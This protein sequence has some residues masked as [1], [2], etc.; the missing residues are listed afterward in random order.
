MTTRP[1]VNLETTYLGMTLPHPVI[2]SAS[3][4]TGDIDR[5]HELAEA[6]APAV[7]LPSLFEEQIEHDAMAVHH[8]FEFGSG[9]FA[10]AIS[11]YFPEVDDCN[12]GPSAYLA[13]VKAATSELNIPVIASLNG[14][15]PGG[16]TLYAKILEDAGVDALELN[17]YLVGADPLESSNDVENRYLDLISQVRSEVDLPLAVK[18]GPYFSSIGHMARRMSEAGADS[19]V[20]FNRFYQPDIDLNTLAVD[21]S[22]VLSSPTEL[23]LTLR[24]IALLHGRI[25][26][27]LAATTGVHEAAEALKLI[28]AG[29]DV[30]MM[31]SALLRHG[32]SH[33]GQVVAG[34][35]S[36][37]SQHEYS[38]VAQAK[39]SL[40]HSNSPHPEAYERA[41]YMRT[42]VAYSSDWRARNARPG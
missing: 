19:L 29:A 32:A 26:C 15:T 13:L 25:D 33:L 1:P 9:A 14:T 3:P 31:A 41:N 7:V 35:E 2:P 24:W 10:E 17:I 42:L 12:S 36:W 39:G 20:L 23:R 28:L 22:L 4:I 18:V 30:V 5:L 11:G 37:L 40:S 6:G 21:P 27:D 16:W 38:S 8:G 34:I